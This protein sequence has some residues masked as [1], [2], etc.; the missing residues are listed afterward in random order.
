MPQRVSLTLPA[1]QRIGTLLFLVAGADK[2]G[3][4]ARAFGESDASRP[5]SGVVAKAAR[6]A[7]WYIDEAA[8]ASL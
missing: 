6:R 1:F 7:L 8:A 5:P 3:P 4:L 2:A